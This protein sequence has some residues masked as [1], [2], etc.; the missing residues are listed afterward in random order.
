LKGR[1]GKKGKKEQK[2]TGLK[3]KRKGMERSVFLA[4]RQKRYGAKEVDRRG[5]RG[6]PFRGDGKK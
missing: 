2:E 3:K 6:G 5:G 1:E 4:R